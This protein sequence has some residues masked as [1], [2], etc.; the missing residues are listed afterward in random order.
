[1]KTQ[2]YLSIIAIFL[3]NQAVMS[4]ISFT[5]NI[6]DNNQ[7]TANAANSVTTADFDGDGDID[8]VGAA[9][10]ADVF[11]L[12]RNDGN[13]NF[14]RETIDN[15]AASD[16]PRFVTS[17]D[18]DQ[19]GDVDVLA[20]ASTANN[21]LWFENDGS[22]TFSLHIIDNSPLSNEAYAIDAADF[23]LDGTMDIVGGANNGDAL[24][25]YSND[26]SEN[27]T[28]LIDLSAGGNGTNGVRAVQAVDLNDDTF[29]DILVAAFSGDTYI[30][31]EGAGNGQFTP[32]VIDDSPDA[33]GAT[34]IDA[35]DLDAD[36]DLDIVGASNNAD[37][38]VWYE[39]DGN[40]NF[41][42]HII[43]NTSN[44]SIGPRGIAVVDLD[45]DGDIDVLGA[46]ITGDAFAWYEN[47]GTGNFITGTISVDPTY[48]NGAFA[49][50]TGDINGDQ[51][52]DIVTAANIADVFSWF[53]TEGVV[54][55]VSENILSVVKIYPIP[56]SKTLTIEVSENVIVLSIQFTNSQG[57]VIFEELT[58]KT[59]TFEIDVEKF[60]SGIYF[61]SAETN[62]GK[63]TSKFIKN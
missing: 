59:G 24:A 9:F 48:S 20:A 62:R 47:D 38:Y 11:S 7:A 18:L 15:S 56:V 34:G 46:A 14:S 2:L 31:F 27:F 42:V 19:D 3:F 32:H 52:E 55:S 5:A 49:I 50:T 63:M 60:A 43:D 61:L 36:G 39:N 54:L 51:V 1:M 6:I 30:W 35:A 10:Q 23:N 53:E 25:V 44:L 29:M 16:G 40:E 26:G 12:Y 28:L 13:G 17:F 22:G 37:Q 4:Q 33:D 8:V 58:S 57:R 41:S 45:N 21:Y